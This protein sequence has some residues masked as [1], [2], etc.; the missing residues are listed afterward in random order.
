MIVTP[1]LSTAENAQVDVSPAAC[2][3]L[4]ERSPAAVAAH[5]KAAWLALFARYSIVEDPVGSV[6]HVSG[7]Y[8][9]RWGYRGAG[10]L[11]R[12]YETFIAANSIRFHVDQDIV[13]GSHVMRDIAIEIRMSDKVT[14]RVPVHLLYEL[15]VQEGALKIQ[16]LAAH[17]ELW[18][19]L[20]Q[21]TAA[22]LPFLRVG[23]ASSRRMLQ[24]LGWRG[25][26]GFVS[27]LR[28]VGDEGKARVDTFVRLFN[29][30][31]VTALRGLLLQPNRD[32]AFH[33]GQ[34]P[35][36]LGEIVAAGGQLS[37]SKVMAAGNIV[38]ATV[39]YKLR[40]KSQRGVALFELHQ[41]SMKL[42]GVTCY[43]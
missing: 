6:A 24:H 20:K 27:A 25:T 21:Q 2:L 3:A 5:D 12:F 9:T 4:A 13:S 10:R 34:P 32:L 15:I 35:R 28:S 7:G 33:H 1:K 14:V 26:L 18:P 30:G 38:S 31:D 29:A 39:H 16:R 37:L 22:G 8:D 41:P 43:W 19:M 23:L 42:V 17:W 36:P 40:E 11:D